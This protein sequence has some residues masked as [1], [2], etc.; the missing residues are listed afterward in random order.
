MNLN[1]RDLTSKTKFS[2]WVKIAYTWNDHRIDYSEF[3][4]SIMVYVPH[5]L[6]YI[7]V[8]F[9]GFVFVVV[10][11][12][13]LTKPDMF[14]QPRNCLCYIYIYIVF[15]AGGGEGLTKHVVF[16]PPLLPWNCLCYILFSWQVAVKALSS[17][18][19]SSPS[20]PLELF[21]LYIVFV[22][23]GREGLTKHAVFNPLFS[24]GIVYVIY[25]FCGRWRWRPYRAVTCSSPFWPCQGKRARGQ[26]SYIPWCRT[27]KTML[28]PL[29]KS[30]AF[31][32]TFIE[33][34]L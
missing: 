8:C 22:A 3:S 29:G 11:S 2:N 31:S 33:W 21:M 26:T 24:P 15:V 14:I 17:M 1:L 23:G 12:E 32:M 28:L 5:L 19:C 10:S 25:C 4:E 16:I 9:S 27:W 6:Y 7:V 13:G 18:L 34:I 30:C 20:S